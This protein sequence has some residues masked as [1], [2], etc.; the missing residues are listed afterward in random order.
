M[1]K[2]RK[3]DIARQ[4][5]EREK[6]QGIFAVRCTA[7]GETWVGSTPDLET[8]QNGIWA[9]LRWGRHPNAEMQ[10]SW[11]AHGEESFAFEIVEEVRD[12]NPLLIPA[13][14]KERSLHWIREFSGGPIV[15]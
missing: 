1:D 7:T 3:R 15:G 2:N 10:S 14:L 13:L 5:K 12:D 11:N 4:Y 9:A 6:S 8:R